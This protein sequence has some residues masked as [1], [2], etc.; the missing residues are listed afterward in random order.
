MVSSNTSSSSPALEAALA[1]VPTTFRHKIITSYIEIKK[2]Y[3][4]ALFDA[5]FDSAGLSSGKFTESVFRC[6]QHSLTGTHI[7]FGKNI[8]NFADE[9]RKLIQLP[10][11]AG[12]ESLRV[13]I[14]RALVFLYTIRG[15][16]GI[17][18]VG[19]DV[20]A[21]A[22]DTATIVRVADWIVCELIRVF[23]HLSL[24]EAQAIVD[25]LSAR[26]IPF[27]WEVG[28]VRRILRTDLDY[29]QMVL[30]LAYDNVDGVM[31]E[32]LFQS[33]E[34]SNLAMFKKSVLGLL[35]KQRFIEYDKQNECVYLSPLGVQHVEEMILPQAIGR[36]Q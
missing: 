1:D 32:D 27:I 26:N 7:P 25:A 36:Q 18:H 30:L 2:R 10:S 22:I 15:K 23:H 17:G 35:H 6:L 14:P 16:R 4:K 34:Y 3:S 12:I 24:E 19:G 20:E 11:A 29:K 21:N 9:C 8:P 5:S 13:I 28:G 31:V 33:T